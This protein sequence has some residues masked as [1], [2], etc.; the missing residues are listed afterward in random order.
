MYNS[1]IN[2]IFRY[3]YLFN[4]L[5]YY[6]IEE[7]FTSLHVLTIAFSSLK[8]KVVT[9]VGIRTPNPFITNKAI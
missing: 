6:H 7:R 5:I 2:I 9:F 1:K 3:I 4:I 8:E